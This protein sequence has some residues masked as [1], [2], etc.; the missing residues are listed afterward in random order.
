MRNRV[1]LLCA[2]ALAIT[3]AAAQRAHYLDPRDVAEAQREN[4]QVVEELGGEETGPRAAYVESIG[5]RVA[6]FSGVA[7]VGQSLHFT[8]L[9][10]A[11]ENAFSVPGGYV[12]LTRQL[13]AIMDDESQLAFA[14][15]HEVG[16]I[17]ASHAR[18]RE[19][20]AARNPLSVIARVLGSFGDPYLG[21]VLQ[22]R[23]RLQQ[24]SFS[25]DQEY[26]ADTLGLRYMIAAG[27]DPA[28]A[29]QLL[30]ALSRETAL[31]A[32]VQGRA[33]RQT[34]EWA[35][36]H[37]LSENRMQRALD[38][39]RQTGRL[40]TGLHNRDTFLSEIEGIYV[41]DDP[42]QGVIDGPGVH[43][44]GPAYPVPGPAGLL[45]VQRHP[46]GDGLG[47]GRKGA[48]RFRRLQR[49]AQRLHPAAVQ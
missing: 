46:C 32:R 2:A 13:L 31:Q 48:I 30:A 6:A 23:A 21:S 49:L 18:Q 22:A 4:A 3:P 41:D 16:H 15:G 37:P 39:A 38:E 36:T 1:L 29:A 43:P 11:V 26:Q 28:G 33:N 47:F 7:N 14:L 17:A 34:P 35:S 27:Y 9:N 24:L 40:G 25:R 45:D 5:R 19:E 10:S 8:T 12:Y 20:Y 44:S 42:K